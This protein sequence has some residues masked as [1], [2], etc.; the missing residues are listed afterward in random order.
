MIQSWKDAILVY[1]ESIIHFSKINTKVIIFLYLNVLEWPDYLLLYARSCVSTTFPQGQPGKSWALEVSPRQTCFKMAF[2]LVNFYCQ[3]DI[4]YS[5]LGRGNT[6]KELSRPDW[7]VVTSVMVLIDDGC[8][9]GPVHTTSST[10]LCLKK[11]AEHKPVNQSAIFLDGFW[12]RFLL[13]LMPW[14]PSMTECEN[15][16]WNGKLQ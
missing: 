14:F 9:E 1:F 5:H 7:P 4:I 2:V 16:N 11:S 12:A 10:I 6:I 15:G 8:W 13:E 3:L